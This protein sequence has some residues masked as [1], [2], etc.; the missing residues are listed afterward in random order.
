M[1]ILNVSKILMAGEIRRD[2]YTNTVLGDVSAIFGQLD[3]SIGATD[4][5]ILDRLDFGEICAGPDSGIQLA[6]TQRDDA[7]GHDNLQKTVICN[8]A[9]GKLP[10]ISSL[11]PPFS[12]YPDDKIDTLARVV[13]HEMTHYDMVAAGAGVSQI[14]DAF[15]KDEQRAYGADRSHALVDPD[16]DDDPGLADVNADNYAWF[17]MDAYISFTFSSNP[18]D[19]PNYFQNPPHY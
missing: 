18:D 9:F 6:Y 7:E 17:A 3:P 14:T 1:M 13:L 2:R 8:W 4:T 5:M 15:N 12:A 16:Q 10:A 19:A 11:Q